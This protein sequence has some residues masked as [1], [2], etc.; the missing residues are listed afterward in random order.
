MRADRRNQEQQSR[1]PQI[2]RSLSRQG[3]SLPFQII[4]T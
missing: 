1:K 2:L 4:L 3:N